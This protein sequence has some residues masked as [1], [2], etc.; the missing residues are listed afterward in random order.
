MLDLIAGSLEL[1]GLWKIGNK[2]RKGFLFNIICN[3]CWI[4]YVFTSKSTYGLL[5]VVMP[6]LIINIRNFIKWKP[7]K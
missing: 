1:I 4:I 6:A 2:N 7:T 5:I 3:I